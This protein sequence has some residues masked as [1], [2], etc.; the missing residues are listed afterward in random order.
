MTNIQVPFDN[1]GMP[2]RSPDYKITIADIWYYMLQHWWWFVISVAICGTAAWYYCAKQ[3]QIYY[4]QA[5]VVIKDPENKNYSAGLE[6]YDNYIN[7]VNVAN[8]VLQFKSATLMTEVV[9]RI[10]ANVSYRLEDSIRVRELYHGSPV[11]VSF[12]MVDNEKYVAFTVTPVDSTTVMVS[13]IAGVPDHD[14][15]YRM[16]VGATLDLGIN[17][18]VK[19][20]STRRYTPYWYGR[21]IRVVHLPLSDAVAYFQ[22]SMSI[23]QAEDESSIL[24]FA[25]Q[26]V[27]PQ[28]CEDIIN[29]LVDVYN[30]EAIND[31]NRVAVNTAQ[32]INER[33]H[34]IE[35]EL[36]SVEQDLQNYK[37]SKGIVDITSATM[38]YMQESER[39]DA[40]EVE[41][42]AQLEWANYVKDYLSDPATENDLIPT[43]SGL[44]GVNLEDQITQ[45]NALQLKRQRL[46]RE[47]GDINPVITEIDDR[48]VS[49]REATIRSV[50]NLITK[51]NQRRQNTSQQQLKSIGQIANLPE[52]QREMLS[53]ER[54][55][56]IKETLYVFLLNKREENALTQAMADNNA[57]MIDTPKGPKAPIAPQPKRTIAMGILLGMLIPGGFLLVNMFMDTRV[58]SRKDLEGKL[59]IPFLGEIPYDKDKAKLTSPK[60]L[61][62]TGDA[63][64]MLAEAFRMLRTNLMFFN[65]PDQPVQVITLSSFNEGAGKTFIALNLAKAL[66]KAKKKVVL[67][68]LDVRKGTLS[69][70][71]RAQGNGVTNYLADPNN[72]EIIKSLGAF[73]Y[74]PSGAV[75]PNPAEL[76]MEPMLD[77]LMET[78]RQEYDYIIVDNV[79]VGVVADATIANR[80]ADLTIF[81]ARVGKLDK[82]QIPDIEMLH[83]EG[84]LRNMAL[85]LNGADV[86]SRYGYYGRYGYRR[87][88]Y[89]RYGY[90][91]YGKKKK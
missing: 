47:S 62:E 19:V 89:H 87:Y 43:Y 2:Q 54:Q 15:Y 42:I 66:A 31:K 16:E 77:R 51:L 4:R 12:D 30:E 61:L 33:L 48:L 14:N 7:R 9:R 86:S 27:S 67:L 5:T 39:Y 85:V 70:Q 72:N 81:V 38:R 11:R 24:T 26:D 88:G 76:L 21:D 55:Q 84:K 56:K 10:D 71:L 83:R 46:A 6:R 44:V 74:I 73:D 35:S 79:P 34:I 82:R 59:N 45:F 58:H 63:D 32:F 69:R 3:P 37:K 41:E 49:L 91:S 29:T 64:D 65:R 1:Y 40:Q 20:S 18:D 52:T 57:K 75:P 13:D 22:G 17:G 80:I 28:R 60:A 53:I 25:I 68:D 23:R 50:S 8:E 78:L 90:Y 36:G